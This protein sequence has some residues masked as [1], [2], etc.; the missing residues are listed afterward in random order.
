MVLLDEKERTPTYEEADDLRSLS[1]A[2]HAC[3]PSEGCGHDVFG[4][5]ERLT[6]PRLEVL[7]LSEAS[8]DSG[9]CVAMV[10]RHSNTLQE[11]KRGSEWF[12]IATQLGQSVRL[13]RISLLSTIGRFCLRTINMRG[14][15][16]HDAMFFCKHCQWTGYRRQK[17]LS[18]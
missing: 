7:E 2:I 11:S 8:L 10:C 16:A 9:G 4:L 15:N 3:G 13:R 17:T 1:L 5:F 6:W 12:E 18:L 14:V